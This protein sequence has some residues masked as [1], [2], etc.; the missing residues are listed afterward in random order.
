MSE[1]ARI[2]VGY[3]FILCFSLSVS[4][5]TYTVTK[6]ADTNDGACDSDCSLREAITAANATIDND[7]IEFSALFNTPQTITLSGTDLIIDNNGTLTINGTGAD[8][9]TV[10]GNNASR[11]FTNNTGAV[12]ALNRLRVTGGT[13]TSSVMSGR[14]GGIYNNG[15]T[16]TLNFLNITG[17][18]AANGGGVN[19]AG[20]ATISINN[21]AIFAN[22]ATGA[23]G[24]LQNFAGNTTN[25][26]NSS[27]YG[28]TCNS[29]GTGGGGMQ[30]NGTINIVNST[31]SGNNSVGG[32][33]GA[34][35]YNGTVLNITNSTFSENISTNNGAIHKS[36]ATPLNIRNTIVDGNNG[37]AASPDVTGAV[38]SLGNNAIG[39][40]GTSTG[41]IASDF[42]HLVPLL[43]I[44]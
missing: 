18:T 31:F 10:S 12:T 3:L 42:Q 33:G 34:I 43:G 15:G 1:F 41:W 11:V 22:M 16:L 26:F 36:G 23:G 13:G 21:T 39:N 9:I 35:Y 14:G 17:N 4:A 7:V 28:N 30:A 27:I 19:N 8:K 20:T 32:S 38:N 44:F 6:I 40:Y 29:T 25:I 2:F 5:T 24:G 37:A